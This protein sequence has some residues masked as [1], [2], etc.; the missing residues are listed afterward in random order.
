[1]GWYAVVRIHLEPNSCIRQFQ[2]ADSNWD[3]RSVVTVDGT[4]NR[5][6]HP[7]INGWATDSTVTSLI[8]TASGHRVKWSMQVR[9]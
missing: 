4:P 1:M 7:L 5:E 3:P 9:I 6:I 8:G 2:R